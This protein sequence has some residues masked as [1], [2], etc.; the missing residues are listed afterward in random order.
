M[1]KILLLLIPLLAMIALGS[2]IAW[3]DISLNLYYN[4]EIY[5]LENDAVNKNGRYY[6]EAHEAAQILGLELTVDLL[7]KT[8]SI[9][10]GKSVSTYS[11]KPLDYSIVTLRAYNPNIP[12]I[13]ND[14]FYLPFEFI[15]EKFNV[16]IKY[17]K[18]FGSIYFLTDE[19]FKLFNNITHGYLLEVP[20]YSSI[21]FSGPS[22]SF[23]DNSIV[24]VDEDREFTYSINCDK[25]NSSSIA[26]MRLILNDYNSSDKQ[27]FEEISNYTKSYFRAMQALYKSEFLFSGS[28]PAKNESNIKIFADY[29]EDIYG[30]LSNVILYNSIKSDRYS[31]SEDTY[32]SITTPIYS[33]MSIYTIN[34]SGK[35]GFLTKKNIDKITGLINALKIQNLPDNENT[36]EIFND[37]KIVKDANSG[38]YPALCEDNVEYTEYENLQQ[39]YKIRYPSTFVPYFQNSVINSLDF[40]SFKIDY[41]NYIS[42]SAEEI[43]DPDAPIKNKIALVKSS[44]S[45]GANAVEEGNSLLSGKEFYY[46]KYE[47]K[48]G[49]DLYYVQGYYTVYNSK[50][51][52]IE[53]NTRF[54]R[55]SD[56]IID[57]FL[58]IVESIEFTKPD[59]TSFAVS[60]SFKKYLNE[61]EGYSFS[62]P[63]T[64]ELKDK[65][66]DINFDS[67]SVVSPEY[68]GPLDIRINESEC[69][70]NASTEELLRLFSGNN[71]EFLLNYTANYYAPYNTR[72][73][74]VLNTSSKV[75]NDIIY[76]YRLVNFLDESQRHKLGYSMDIIRDGRIYTL[77]I[78][79]S[80][81]LIS[82]GSV[83]DKELGRILSTIAESFTLEQTTEYL[84]RKSTGETRNRKVVFLEDCFKLILGRSTTLTSARTLDSNGDVLVQIS[85][86]KE[87]GTYRLKFD[88]ERKNL[89]IISAVMQ[90]DALNSAEHNLREMY[91]DKVIHSITPSHDNMALT[92]RHSDGFDLP[93]AEKIYFIDV[94]PLEGDFDIRLLRSYTTP[95]LKEKCQSYLENCLLTKVEVQ[96]PKGYRYSR[97][98]LSKVG[99]KAHF[100][101]V[102]AQYG[103]KS[104]Y[105]LLKIDPF[106]DSISAVS[107]VPSDEI[108]EVSISSYKSLQL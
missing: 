101:N 105:F 30:Q 42:I 106:L 54:E 32:I 53:L 47:T 91:S 71:A 68:S 65:S 14:K 64:W 83:T 87:A 96:F 75:E 23:D 2:S 40:I 93:V 37:P 18:K 1:K 67:F 97:K 19:D 43:Q 58:K 44:P 34:I 104:G 38:I 45:V 16:I 100:I 7:N 50:L 63:D 55:P 13:I 72:S 21:D 28:D 69:L 31:S 76:I 22:D 24:L 103:S 12:E 86:C 99:Y 4:G 89:E 33:N 94:L 15:E 98:H 62:Y 80:D 102:F 39:N 8:L 48:D 78:S 29:S 6:L 59:Q 88:Y 90:K 82:N 25:L 20:S 36:L 9:Y 81:Y 10:D 77:F 74:K 60:T 61:H 84:K 41:N 17:D 27:I 108:E 3:A 46:V 11:A 66:T 85:N 26:G 70:I 49:L 95:E 107:F 79:T 35:K 73:A 51:Y 57:E 52:K 56:A 5:V 92:I